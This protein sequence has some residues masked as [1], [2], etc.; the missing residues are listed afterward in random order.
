MR[1]KLTVTAL[2]LLLAGCAGASPAPVKSTPA[3]KPSPAVSI[4]KTSG[5]EKACVAFTDATAGV[6]TPARLAQTLNSL[7]V[8]SALLLAATKWIVT[9]SLV[10]EAP[11]AAL[12]AQV[13]V[14]VES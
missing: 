8:S 5:N 3:A 13:G 14:T 12:C 11:V 2:A 10:N 6:I 1:A 4:P 9:P 7:D